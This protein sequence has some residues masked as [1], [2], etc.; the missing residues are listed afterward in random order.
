M[1]TT[2]ATEA[3]TEHAEHHELSF[4]RKYIFSTDHKM[5]ARQFLFSALMFLLL[6]G[7]LAVMI[8]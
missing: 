5:I 8:R 6:G 2:T 4:V 3:H 1:S 7:L